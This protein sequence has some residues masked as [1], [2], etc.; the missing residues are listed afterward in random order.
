ML[1]NYN[2]VVFE[3]LGSHINEAKQ[4]LNKDKG[5]TKNAR[6]LFKVYQM[7]YDMSNKIK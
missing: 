1:K 5:K 6:C 7:N 3:K 4:H 2:K